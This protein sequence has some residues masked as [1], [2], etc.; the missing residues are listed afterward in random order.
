MSSN[1]DLPLLEC[2]LSGTGKMT[3]FDERFYEHVVGV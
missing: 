3:E 2:C 1:L